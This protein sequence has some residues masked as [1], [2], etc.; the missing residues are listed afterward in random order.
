MVQ[1]KYPNATIEDTSYTKDGAATA[2]E[3][4]DDPID[5]PN[6]ATKVLSTSGDPL[7]VGIDAPLDPNESYDQ[8]VLRIRAQMGGPDTCDVDVEI[9]EG[10][11]LRNIDGLG[12]IPEG[13]TDFEITYDFVAIGLFD[14]SAISV[15]LVPNKPTSDPFEVS[16]IELVVPDRRA[17]VHVFA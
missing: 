1:R 10:A 9:Y 6:D 5:T 16:S 17:H 7:Q 12:T 14:Y 2:H 15:R 3:C 8:I 11:E 4:I 13:W